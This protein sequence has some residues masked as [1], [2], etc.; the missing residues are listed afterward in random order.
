MEMDGPVFAFSRVYGTVALRISPFCLQ[1]QDWMLAFEGFRA[2]VV[3]GT[4]LPI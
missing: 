4:N 3:V 2:L 1:V